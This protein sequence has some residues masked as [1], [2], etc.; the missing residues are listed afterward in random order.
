MSN[1]NTTYFTCGVKGCTHVQP[2]DRP[3]DIRRF[4]TCK[5]HMVDHYK[6]DHADMIGTRVNTAPPGVAFGDRYIYRP[7]PD[8]IGPTLTD[9]DDTYTWADVK[10]YFD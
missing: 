8:A 9:N 2:I 3:E 7:I 4:Q 5:D 10:K 1:K 6:W